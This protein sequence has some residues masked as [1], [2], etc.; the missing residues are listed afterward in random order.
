MNYLM[1]RLHRN[2]LFFA[3]GAIAALSVLLLVTG[4]KMANDYHPFLSSCAATQSCSDGGQLFSGDGA[5]LD[6][7]NLTIVVPLLFGLFWGAPLISKEFEDGTHNLVWTQGVTRSSWLRA[8]VFW[9]FLAAAA[10]GGVVALVVSWWR[11][12]ENAL[13]GQFSAFDVQGI[14]P[15]AYSLFAVGLG[16]TIGSLVRRVQ[17]AIAV[18]LGVFVAL[19]VAIGIYLRPRFLA[20]LTQILPIGTKGSLPSS[21][22]I[23]SSGIVGPG[24]QHYGTSFSPQDVPAVC[25]VGDVAEKGISIPCLVSHGFRQLT[26]YQPAGRFWEFQGIEA[27]IFLVLT[28]ALVGF[29][30]WRVLS[31]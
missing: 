6:L 18:T 26:T 30:Y 7:V 23:I 20:P 3:A 17:L 29:A 15:V 10:W 28:A 8:N 2:Q 25:K 19:R 16:T 22:W 31:E 21:G 24:G 5:I 1:W 4:I 12:P 14:A 9:A 11:F 13:Y 27:G